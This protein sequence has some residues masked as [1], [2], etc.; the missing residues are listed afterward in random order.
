ML[1]DSHI[2]KRTEISRLQKEIKKCRVKLFSMGTL[3]MIPLMVVL[4]EVLASAAHAVD[5]SGESEW[6]LTELSTGS[7]LLVMTIWTAPLLLMI[8]ASCR[9]MGADRDSL[10]ELKQEPSEQSFK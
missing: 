8:K 10:F 4:A 9:Q 2:E 6:F 1:D 3:A 5:A 7:V